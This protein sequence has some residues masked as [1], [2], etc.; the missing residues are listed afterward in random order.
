MHFSLPTE[1]IKTFGF[2]I[3]SGGREIVHWEQMDQ[4]IIWEVYI[5][6]DSALWHKRG[7]G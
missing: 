6:Q 1:Y 7:I 4:I 2:L 3:F 5:T